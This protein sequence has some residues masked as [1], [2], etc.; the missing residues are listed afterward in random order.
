MPVKTLE[1]EIQFFLHTEPLE[2]DAKIGKDLLSGF[3]KKNPSFAA[4][5]VMPGK[6]LQF[7]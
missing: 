1:E 6:C 4:R 7:Y 2:R 5:N 3:F